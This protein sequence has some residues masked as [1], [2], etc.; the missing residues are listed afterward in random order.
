MPDPGESWPGRSFKD[1]QHYKAESACY[2]ENRGGT[3]AEAGLSRLLACLRRAVFHLW[4]GFLGA[5]KYLLPLTAVFLLIAVGMLAFRASRRRDYMPSILGVF[6]AALLMY[7]NFSL[8]S[9][10]ILYAGFGL[11]IVA[12]VWNSWS[13]PLPCE[14]APAAK[15][16][17]SG[18]LKEK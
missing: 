15:L 14:C 2:A 5:T 9:N 7:V 12:S 18:A 8:G 17:P 3:P 16:G 10:P 4:P 13:L 1:E 6:A 11:L